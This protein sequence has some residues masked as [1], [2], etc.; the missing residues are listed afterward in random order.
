MTTQGTRLAPCPFCGGNDISTIVRPDIRD[1][2]YASCEQCGGEGPSV[3]TLGSKDAAIAAWNRRASPVA[4]EGGEPVA[5]LGGENER[6]C[7]ETAMRQWLSSL[8]RPDLSDRD[9]VIGAIE[10]FKRQ[11]IALQILAAPA[12]ATP[13]EG[14]VT[15]GMVEAASAA[16]AKETGYYVEFHRGLRSESA[17]KIRRGMRSALAAALSQEAGQ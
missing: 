6:I 16:Y 9:R 14:L 1:G 3:P 15:E 4:P 17:D 10:A 11:A 13:V 12:P 8:K 7:D 2:R 5:W